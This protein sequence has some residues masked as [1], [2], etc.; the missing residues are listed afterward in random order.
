MI[1]PVD[2]GA[3]APGAG[4]REEAAEG[5]LL[6]APLERRDGGDGEGDDHHEAGVDEGGAEERDEPRGCDDLARAREYE[7]GRRKPCVAERLRDDEH[8]R[9]VE[10]GEGDGADERARGTTGSLGGNGG[11]DPSD[12]EDDTRADAAD[13]QAEGAV[14][15]DHAE[16]REERPE[17]EE[18]RQVREGERE[19]GVARD[20]ARGP[21]SEGEAGM[22]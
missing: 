22:R 3:A 6:R 9:E 21:I 15:A 10:R 4:R 17:E 18:A 1:D 20:V 8:P 13:D 2:H 11:G 19:K 5:L 14:L 16:E 7:R 12:D